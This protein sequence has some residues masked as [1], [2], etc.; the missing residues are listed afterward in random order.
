VVALEHG[1]EVRITAGLYRGFR[2]QAQDTD[3]ERTRVSVVVRV[4]GRPTRL[5]LD[6]FSVERL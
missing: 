3:S 5:E 4:F 1:D 6:G 2:G